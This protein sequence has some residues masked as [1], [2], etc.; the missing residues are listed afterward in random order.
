MEKYVFENDVK[1]FGTEVKTFPAGID[2]AFDELIIET[3]D[4]AGMRNYYGISSMKNDGK[5]IYKAV[6]EECY[7]GEAAKHN[8]EESIIEKGEYLF[9]LL[10][11]W[12]SK[13]ACIKDIFYAMMKDDRVDKTK[14]CVEWYKND[15]EM[16]CMVKM[17]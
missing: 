10:K 6:T 9:E 14:P 12:R 8:Y 11:D 16:Y 1:V 5:M 4:G 2:G 15:E 3:G 17:I 7:E 13:T